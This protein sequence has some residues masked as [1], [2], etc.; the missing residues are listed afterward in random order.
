M[1][2]RTVAPQRGE[3]ASWEYPVGFVLALVGSTG[4]ECRP[5]PPP[6]EQAAI[7]PSCG[8]GRLPRPDHLWRAESL[9]LTIQKLSHDRERAEALAEGREETPTLKRRLWWTGMIVFAVG[10]GW[11]R[12]PMPAAGCGSLVSRGRLDFVAFSLSPQAIV[13]LVGCWALIVNLCGRP[14]GP[15]LRSVPFVAQGTRLAASSARS[16]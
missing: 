7:G 15:R 11:A 14:G 3:R 13:I 10:N 16:G 5:L 6:F 9:G 2:T 8:A 4:G 1:L 12:A